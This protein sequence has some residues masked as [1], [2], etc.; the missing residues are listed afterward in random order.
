MI[1]DFPEVE[2]HYTVE[3]LGRLPDKQL[4]SAIKRAFDLSVSAAA[5]LLLMIPMMI[6]ALLIVADSPGKPIYA[7]LRLGKNEKPFKLLKFRSMR[8]DAEESGL[9]WA[10]ENDTRVTKIGNWMRK[11]R[12]DELPQLINILLGQMSFVGPRPE[13]PEFYDLFDTYIDGFR[14]RMVVIP[15]LTGLAQ[16]NGG[17]DLL[18]EQKIVYDIQYIKNRSLKMDMLCILKTIGVIFGRKGAR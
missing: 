14:Q 2:M 4:Y 5:I 12:V 8:A 17:Y 3:A 10:E 16:V 7:Q 1:W 13:R 18:P 9:R 11:T 6:L 15:G